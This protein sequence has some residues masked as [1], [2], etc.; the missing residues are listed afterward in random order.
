MHGSSRI[1]RLVEVVVIFG[2]AVTLIGGLIGHSLAK[3]G[4]GAI[5]GILAL[6]FIEIVIRQ[7]R[8]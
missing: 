5:I 6:V 4:A 3:A 7:K 8:E 1:S 2:I